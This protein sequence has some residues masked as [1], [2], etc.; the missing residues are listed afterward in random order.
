M[1]QRPGK[2]P[3]FTKQVDDSRGELGDNWKNQPIGFD[4]QRGSRRRSVASGKRMLAH[5]DVRTTTSRSLRHGCLLIHHSGGFNPSRAE[6]RACGPVEQSRPG[7]WTNQ[8]RPAATRVARS[9][10]TRSGKER[11]TRKVCGKRQSRGENKLNEA[12]LGGPRLG[13]AIP[14]RTLRAP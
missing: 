9:T 13:D 1:T 3:S 7:H 12:G 4:L 8:S 5:H 2:S 10:K 11:H 6:W 14:P